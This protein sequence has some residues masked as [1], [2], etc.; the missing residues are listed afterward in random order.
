MAS[1]TTEG[2]RRVASLQKEDGRYFLM[3]LLNMDFD[4]DRDLKPGILLDYLYNAIMFAVQ[5]GFPWPNVVLVARFSEELLEETMGITIT[6]AIGMLK[7][8]CDQYQY[9]MKPKQFKLLVNYFL[10]TFFKH[11]RLYQ[12]V[13]LEV[14][15]MDQT[16]HNLEVYVPQKP[17]ALKDGTEADV[18]IYQKRISELNETENQLQAEMLFLRQTSQLESERKL[19]QFYQRLKLKD[20]IVLES[21][22]VEKIVKEAQDILMKI[23]SETLENV[24]RT[25]FEILD[26][27]L[28]KR[29]LPQPASNANVLKKKILSKFKKS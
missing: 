29:V 22:K 17:L 3:T 16:I 19:E 8:K 2:V 27:K 9:T 12:F 5:K 26:I 13:L 11:Y 24:I 18:W 6:E 21:E 28:Q 14:R 10:E 7:K 4:E 23:A 1:L 25:S 20:K 15:E